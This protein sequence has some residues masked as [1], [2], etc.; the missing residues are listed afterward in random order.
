MIIEVSTTNALIAA[1]GI[2][3]AAVISKG[4][5]H[6]EQRRTRERVAKIQDQVTP[7]NGTKLHEMTQQA[8]IK[9]GQAMIE[10]TEAK[11][12]AIEAKQQSAKAFLWQ[13]RHETDYRHDRRLVE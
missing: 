11:I 2:I 6:K 7:D 10:A 13:G 4:I 9:A 5:G 3:G 8:S 1:G 12:A